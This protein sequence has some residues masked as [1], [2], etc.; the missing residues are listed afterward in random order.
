MGVQTVAFRR[1]SKKLNELAEQLYL[2]EEP[3]VLS[4]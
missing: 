2:T 4:D 1:S 3:L